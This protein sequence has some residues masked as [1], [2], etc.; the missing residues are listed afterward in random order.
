MLGI[1]ITFGCGVYEKYQNYN[2]NFYSI[3]K[4]D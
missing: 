3:I 2:Q 4:Y 1:G